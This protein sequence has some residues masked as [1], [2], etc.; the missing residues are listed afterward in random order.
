MF[1]FAMTKYLRISAFIVSNTIKH[2]NN[3]RRNQITIKTLDYLNNKKLK[4][5]WGKFISQMFHTY[6][7][8]NKQ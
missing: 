4:I 5:F 8:A 6:G 1:Y 3:N 7:Q 2:N